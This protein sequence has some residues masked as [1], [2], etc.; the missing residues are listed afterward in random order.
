[1]WAAKEP[2]FY[3]TVFHFKLIKNIIIFKHKHNSFC[4][5]KTIITSGVVT[6]R[7]VERKQYGRF[8]ASSEYFPAQK[9]IYD[10]GK[11]TQQFSFNAVKNTFPLVDA[12][13]WNWLNIKIEGISSP[14]WL[15]GMWLGCIGKWRF[16]AENYV[17]SMYLYRFAL[18]R[19][20]TITHC[21][22]SNIL[23][24]PPLACLTWLL[25]FFYL[26]SISFFVVVIICS[27]NHTYSQRNIGEIIMI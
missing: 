21:F 8:S 13:S 25:F 7:V 19:S 1:M 16:Y 5:S 14:V 18:L 12:H 26:F 24:M 2:N 20:C 3:S 27:I 6:R 22:V 15:F 17:L 23:R 11:Q 4:F 9:T 10:T